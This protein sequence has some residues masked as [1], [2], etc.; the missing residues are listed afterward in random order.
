[1]VIYLP[2]VIACFALLSFLKRDFL[3]SKSY[4]HSP[5]SNV[6]SR[7]NGTEFLI[8]FSLLT[9]MFYLK[10]VVRVTLPQLQFALILSMM[11]LA[12]LMEISITNTR[13]FK[14]MLVTLA[15]ISCVATLT[16]SYQRATTG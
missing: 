6:F 11:I 7:T 2:V 5:I 1:M 14:V 13:W 4:P 9:I 10:G 3:L 15:A 16:L 12:L 8:V